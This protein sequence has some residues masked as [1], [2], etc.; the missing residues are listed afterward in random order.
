MKLNHFALKCPVVI[1][2]LVTKKRDAQR[3]VSDRNS[4]IKHRKTDGVI[5]S[6]EELDIL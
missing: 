4:S 1:E 3:E 2:N 6:E 5:D